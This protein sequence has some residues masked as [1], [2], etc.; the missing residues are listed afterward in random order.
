MPPRQAPAA[1]ATEDDRV[2]RMANSTN[3]M[4][5]LKNTIHFQLTN[6]FVIR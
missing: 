1:P 4:A 3:V 6:I 5:N 2:E